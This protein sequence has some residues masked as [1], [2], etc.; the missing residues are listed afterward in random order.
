MRAAIGGQTLSQ[1]KAALLK[2]LLL[3]AGFE[4]CDDEQ[5]KLSQE[6]IEAELSSGNRS[7]PIDWSLKTDCISEGLLAQCPISWQALYCD[8][9]VKGLCYFSDNASAEL[10]QHFCSLARAAF[11]NPAECPNDCPLRMADA[12]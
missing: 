3:E 6:E 1:K 4:I 11:L 12:C 9:L 8:C 7:M 2:D 5:R 10:A